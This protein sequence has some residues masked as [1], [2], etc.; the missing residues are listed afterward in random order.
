M[1]KI[2]KLDDEDEFSAVVKGLY[3]SFKRHDTVLQTFSTA[4]VFNNKIVDVWTYDSVMGNIR[5]SR[6]NKLSL[7]TTKESVLL[8]GHKL[9]PVIVE[10]ELTLKDYGIKSVAAKTAYEALSPVINLKCDFSSPGLEELEKN[11]K[12]VKTRAIGSSINSCGASIKIK[13]IAWHAYKEDLDYEGLYLYLPEYKDWIFVNQL[14][15]SEDTH[16]YGF[17]NR[18]SCSLVDQHANSSLEIDT[19]IFACDDAYITSNVPALTTVEF[20]DHKVLLV[21]TDNLT[22]TYID[23]QSDAFVS[24][25]DLQGEE[26]NFLCGSQENLESMLTNVIH[27]SIPFNVWADTAV[28]EIE[29]LISS[30]TDSG[31][32]ADLDTDGMSWNSNNWSLLIEKLGPKASDLLIEAI[33]ACVGINTPCGHTWEYNDGPYDRASAYDKSPLRCH[34]NISAPSAH[35]QIIAKCNIKNM[36][37]VLSASLVESILNI[38]SK[39]SVGNEQQT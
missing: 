22:D 26:L 20:A 35:E 4:S 33:D 25:G 23:M 34:I 8:E 18:F 39:Q 36:T 21:H 1:R 29:L 37:N 11:N 7:D 19:D 2:K 28:T 10:Q 5:Y 13:P 27:A 3:M 32:A 30:A 24:E 15:L 17:T 31:E 6:S 14:S 12:Y 16:C 9:F 38:N